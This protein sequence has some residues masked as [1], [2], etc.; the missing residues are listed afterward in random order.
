MKMKLTICGIAKIYFGGFMRELNQEFFNDIFKFVSDSDLK[1]LQALLSDAE[2]VLSTLEGG[3]KVRRKLN[4]MQDANGN[5]ILHLAVASNSLPILQILLALDLSLEIVDKGNRTAL[6]LAEQLVEANKCKQDLVTILEIRSGFQQSLPKFSLNRAVKLIKRSLLELNHGNRYDKVL[7]LGPTGAGKS[8]LLNYLNGTRYAL[9]KKIAALCAKPVDGTVAE[10]AK[11]SS[12]G[13]ETL[14]PQI[15]KNPKL[16]FAYCDLAGLFD[17][18]GN[19]ENIAAAISAMLLSKSQGNIKGIVVVLELNNLSSSEKGFAFRKTAAALTLILK[20]EPRLIDSV[21]FAITKVEAER[22]RDFTSHAVIKTYVSPL[23][24]TLSDNGDADEQA[25]IKMLQTIQARPEHIII[26]NITDLGESRENIIKILS[27]LEPKP[28]SL[29]N[30]S[31]YDGSKDEFF[32]VVSEVSN[33]FLLRLQRITREYP[34]TITKLQQLKAMHLEQIAKQKQLI[35]WI[36]TEISIQ[37]KV[38][39]IILN[40]KDVEELQQTPP[41]NLAEINRKLQDSS[42]LLAEINSAPQQQLPTQIASLHTITG[43]TAAERTALLKAE[44]ASRRWLLPWNEENSPRAILTAGVAKL[45]KASNESEQ[46]C[47]E[48]TAKIAECQQYITTLKIE[49]DL[50]QDIY[51]VAAEI[52]EILALDNSP[53]KVFREEYYRFI[54][55]LAVGVHQANAQQRPLMFSDAGCLPMPGFVQKAATPKATGVAYSKPI[56]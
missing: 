2:E 27:S 5:S 41:P 1:S 28:V 11:T 6:E 29:F 33:G 38:D 26:P 20:N 16:N 52:I 14:Y 23:L 49:M 42:R 54:T 7:F 51:A 3:D 48:L 25:L 30:F 37:E 56:V 39:Q 40:W 4:G 43:V 15:V 45:N 10:V 55:G 44:F 8:T 46:L 31:H 50:M 12:F 13:S 24:A 19:E 47:K 9:Y 18:R 35:E 53:Y 32:N 21:R 17:T 22:L 34:D 36:L